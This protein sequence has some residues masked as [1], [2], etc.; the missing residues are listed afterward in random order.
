MY[1]WLQTGTGKAPDE[2]VSHGELEEV[3]QLVEL[4]FEE[5]TV[6]SRST[7]CTDR[8]VENDSA[9]RVLGARILLGS[10]ACFIL[11]RLA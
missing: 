2:V 4:G 1:S 9:D 11:W 8:S 5:R 3:F 6:V 7:G 10:I